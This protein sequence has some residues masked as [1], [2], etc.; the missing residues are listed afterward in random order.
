MTRRPN[1][2]APRPMSSGLDGVDDILGDGGTSQSVWCKSGEAGRF[3]TTRPGLDSTSRNESTT[4]RILSL[5]AQPREGMTLARVAPDPWEEDEPAFLKRSS[6]LWA[7][8]PLWGGTCFWF[9]WKVSLMRPVG[10]Q[11]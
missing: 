5:Q 7:A 10:R 2:H 4:I 1:V 8:L 3:E 9:D 6:S 11:P